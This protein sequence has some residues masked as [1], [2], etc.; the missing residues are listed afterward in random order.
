MFHRPNSDL[1]RVD[2]LQ[3]A[4]FEYFLRYSDPSTG[5]VADTSREGSPS[6]TAATGF[7]LS[8]YPVAVER[9]WIGRDEAVRRVLTTLRFFAGSRQASDAQATGHRGFYYHFLDMRTGERTWR[10]EL[11]TIDST[12]LLVGALT[13]AAYF[14]GASAN[15]AEIRLLAL[16]LYERAEWTWALNRG[17][18]VTMGWRPPGRFLKYRWHG[19]SEAQLLYVL[20][21]GSPT[22]PIAPENYE[23]F[24]TAHEWL[25]VEERTHLHAGALFIH[26]FPHAWIDFRSIRDRGMRERASDYF[27]NT[28]RAIELQRAYAEENPHGFS[29]YC[30]D[31]WGLS[32][33]HAPR[34]WMRLR[35][36]RWQILLGYAARGAPFGADDGTLVPWASLAGLPFEPDACLAS[37][38][39][40][41]WRYPGLMREERL[42]GG[43]NPSLPGAGPEG[44]VDDR[45]VGLDQGLS[46]M[47]IEN[48]RSG[49]IWELTRGIPAI[50][51]GLRKGGFEG[52]WLSAP[53]SRV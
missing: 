34:G 20:A 2:R 50:T 5:L 21:L 12:L 36:G 10:S 16:R 13:A 41:M 35:D 53:V 15:E 27:A 30:R 47:M 7:G 6:S 25:T 18:T 31:L 43:F 42:P 17:D 39:H 28:R 52:G 37:L 44:W 48:W 9:G 38:A 45:I 8:C 46:V 4:A 14:T 26:L 11:S 24:T 3:R 22:H 29:G 51:R 40:L 19:Y 32:A 49:L 23:A 33:C 1:A